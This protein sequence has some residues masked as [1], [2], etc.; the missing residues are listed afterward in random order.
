VV[1][2][3]Q[4]LVVELESILGGVYL[5]MLQLP[6][7]PISRDVEHAQNVWKKTPKRL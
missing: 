6:E 2:A 5:W 4:S 7:R 3:F 1:R